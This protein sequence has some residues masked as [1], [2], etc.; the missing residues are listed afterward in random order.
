[1]STERDKTGVP[2]GADAINPVNGERIPI[3]IADYVLSG[4][5][6]GAIMAVPAHD[7]RDFAFATQFGLEIREVI[8]PAG[9]RGTEGGPLAAA[10]VSKTPD[11]V[12]VNSAT[13]PGW[14]SRTRSGRSPPTW[15]LRDEGRAAV[16][17]RIR[18]W[19]ISRQRYWGTPIP[20]VYCPADGIV[21]VRDSDLPVR[22]PDTVDYHGSGD[23]PLRRDA[24]FVNTTCPRCGGPAQRE[25]DTMDTFMDSSWYWF[26][27]LSPGFEGGPVDRALVDRWTPV[28]QYTGG[29][30]HAVMHLLYSRF[31]TKAMADCGLMSEREPFRRLFNQ[32][33]VLGADGERMSK[34][35]GNVQDP[36]ELV[37]QYGADTVRLFLMFMGPWDQGGPWSPSGIGGVARFIGRAWTL[38]LDPHG[39]EPGDPTSG[40]LPAGEDA[41]AAER[42]IRSAAHRTLAAVGADYAAFH[43]N[44]MVAKLMELSNLLFRY[45][46]TVVAGGSAWDE[47]IGLLLLM[48]APAAPHVTEELWWR[49]LAA[50][51][52]AWRSIHTERWPEVDATAAAVETRELPISVNGKVRDRM[53]IAVGLSDAQVE[54]LVL[55]RPKVIAALGG[56]VPQR[57]IHAGGGRLV[58]IVVRG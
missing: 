37:S 17:Y 41:A 25:T 40:S 3:W 43:F 42:R 48:L 35:R 11:D 12:L 38:A 31:F 49:R 19:L 33:Q 53:E 34:S 21:P 9:A 32:G 18:D 58:N 27:Y 20:V 6:T 7:E 36:D 24:A 13:T 50:R 15:K 57:I 26:R 44:T 22:L 47:A 2:L 28:D 4:Y 16:S 45:R 55:A 46:G 5:G 1:M 29:A 54:A 14:P 52:E 30:E 39:T 23:N 8:R 56:A 10:Y 51:G